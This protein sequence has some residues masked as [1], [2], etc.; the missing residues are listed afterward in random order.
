M[1]IYILD[2]FAGTFICQPCQ[3]LSNGMTLGSY[4]G[5]QVRVASKNIQK[6]R[7]KKPVIGALGW[8]SNKQV[9][10]PWAQQGAV[11]EYIEL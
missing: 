6:L 11:L 4:E 7:K 3:P 1:E 10:V 8:I 2:N 9:I 5:I